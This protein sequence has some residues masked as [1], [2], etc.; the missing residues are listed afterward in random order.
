MREKINVSKECKKWFKCKK[1]NWSKGEINLKQ[2]RSFILY[3]K[4]YIEI[5]VDFRMETK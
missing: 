4:D 1:V 3:S 5:V 2:N